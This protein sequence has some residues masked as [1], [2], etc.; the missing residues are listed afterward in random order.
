MQSLELGI[1]V[2]KS[3]PVNIPSIGR[4]A[5]NNA[6]N[7]VMIA[8]PLELSMLKAKTLPFNK[9]AKLDFCLIF[10]KFLICEK[11]VNFKQRYNANNN[12]TPFKFQHQ[13]GSLPEIV[14]SH[15]K[16]RTWALESMRYQCIVT[17]FVI[18]A[19]MK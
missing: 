12:L 13:V 11:L 6:I 17:S 9:V 14:D 18:H 19:G 5:I 10:Y 15:T 7:F 3:Y 2:I 4:Q 16:H 8:K 1:L